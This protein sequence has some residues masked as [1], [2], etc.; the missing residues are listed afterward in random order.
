MAHRARIASAVAFVAVIG[1]AAVAMR[2]M[3]PQ[4]SDRPAQAMAQAAA[5]FLASLSPELRAKAALPFDGPARQ[6]WHYVPRDRAGVEFA[7]MDEAQRRAARALMRSAL[8][9]QGASKVEEIMLLD[10]VLREMEKGSG[11]RRDPLAYAVAVFGTPG[12]DAWGWKL[13]GHHVSLNFTGAGSA[14][15]VTPAFLGANPAE[16]RTGE[17]AGVRVLA[18]EE[19]LA[20]ELLASLS[21]DERHAAV[22]GDR[23]PDDILA[24]PGRALEQLDGSGLACAAMNPAQRALVERLLAEFARN[25]RHDL[26]EAELARIGAAGMD[27]VR[28]AWMGSD[29]RG[30]GHYWR[31][32]GPTFVIECDNTQN[33]ANHVHTVW[34]DRQRDFGRDLLREHREAEQGKR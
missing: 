10:A 14:T 18:Q 13:E 9:S 2:T 7:Q 12:A 25:L 33:G 27:A 8:S 31:L 29:R 5:A 1:S 20:R 17:R 30:E 3:A 6:D 22:L 21:D 15:A 23:A 28:F 26:A 32:S 19:D 34:R 16:V 4:A 11:V 24:V